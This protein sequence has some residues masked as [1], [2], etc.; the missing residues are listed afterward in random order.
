MN[1]KCKKIL[2]LG[3]IAVFL[4]MSVVPAINAQTLKNTVVKTTTENKVYDL[5]IITHKDFV[6]ALQPLVCH[7]N[8]MG[9]KTRLVTTCEIY[10]QMYW[11]GR[12]H[13]EKI[14]YFIKNAVEEWE[15]EYVLLVGG[16][17]GQSYQWYVPVRYVK[18]GV[19][20]YPE[21]QYASDLYYADIYDENGSFCSWDS[22]NDKIFGEW[23][24]KD[25]PED[26]Y[27]D[28]HP[29]VAVGRLP[30]RNKFEV[31][32]M[33]DKIIKYE[34]SAYCKPW[35]H[36]MIAIAG[37]T[38]PEYKN[39]NWTGYEG[40]NYA[41]QA[42]NYMENDTTT[43][44]K[45]YTSDGTLTGPMD[46]V[47]AVNKGCGF[48]YFVGHG[49]PMVW[50]NHLPN[51][52]KRIDAFSLRHI[53]MLRNKDENPICVV[54]GCHNLQ[55]DVTVLNN[56]KKGFA[57][58]LGYGVGAPECFGWLMT[59]RIF[60][61]SIATLGCTALGFTKEDKVSFEGGC[62]ELEVEFF[63]QYG[64]DDVDIIGDTWKNAISWY[65]DTY[66]VDWDNT[67]EDTWVDVQIMQT[68]ILFGDPTLKIGGYPPVLIP[69]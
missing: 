1:E 38:Y 66:T 37:D 53:M 64:Q 18:M 48:L 69:K 9:M 46:I 7:K 31:K 44:T 32:T 16:R 35:S 54:S 34:T 22:N 2:V 19:D 45:L 63:R 36:E 52:T 67:S 23:Y 43:V 65:A 29:D 5:L 60:G 33:V 49:N 12:D 39:S 28:L 3:I 41:D 17:K 4:G 62:N 13:A 57:I 59:H 6:K 14:K 25:G 42:I 68:W 8:H 58:G 10:H 30:C 15:I 51:S 56:I 50:T 47:K 61:G 26:K 11:Q 20:G 27:I 40:E 24:K 55:F 21:P